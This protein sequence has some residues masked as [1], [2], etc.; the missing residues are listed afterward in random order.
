MTAGDVRLDVWLWA[1][2]FFCSRSLARQA[3]EGG[4]VELN[5]ERAKPSKTIRARDRLRIRRGN[6]CYD[7]IV[8]DVATQ[9]GPASVAQLLYA[10]TEASRI[11]REREAALR[12]LGQV[13]MLHPQGRPDKHDR[14]RLR[15]LK[16]GQ[17]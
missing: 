11:D 16:E 10:E 4:K 1:A 17:A 15:D 5:D 12:R 3:V 8:L 2:R 9:R 7:V 14:R 13:G 6:E